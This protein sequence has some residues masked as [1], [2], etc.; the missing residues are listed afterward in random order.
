M[1]VVAHSLLPKLILCFLKA[2]PHP[3]APTAA[4]SGLSGL[5][6]PPPH[7]SGHP[8]SHASRHRRQ[9]SPSAFGSGGGGGGGGGGGL[10]PSGYLPGSPQPP[11]QMASMINDGMQQ[12]RD[13]MA[14]AGS[15]GHSIRPQG[16]GRGRVD[17]RDPEGWAWSGPASRVALQD[18]FSSTITALTVALGPGFCAEV[19]FPLMLNAV[20]L[21]PDASVSFPGLLQVTWREVKRAEVKGEGRWYNVID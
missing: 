9:R 4:T 5:P 19:T 17:R 21:A 3:M 6:P 2:D 8:G 7:P 20:G 12:A 1:R 18:T 11:P 14:S 13:E 16:T 15:L 10:L